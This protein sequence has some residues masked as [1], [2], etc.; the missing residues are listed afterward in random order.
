MR[1]KPVAAVLLLVL[2]AGGG[3]WLFHGHAPQNQYRLAAVEKGPLV[4]TVSASGTVQPV[5]V[6]NV[7]ASTAGILTGLL[8]DFNSEVKAGQPVARLDPASAEAQLAVSRANLEVARSAIDINRAQ[9]EHAKDDALNAQAQLDEA[10]TEVE[11]STVAVAQSGRDF[12]RMRSLSATGDV[13]RSESERARTTYES[14]DSDVK[15]AK[16]K[17]V[18]AGAALAGAQAAAQVADAQLNNAVAAVAAQEAAVRLAEQEVDR[19]LIRAPIDGVVLQRNA[20]LGQPVAPSG[21]PLFVIAQD[22]SNVQVHASV[23]EADIGRVTIGQGATL[24]FD[25]Y[26]DDSF[27]GKVIGIRKT[28]Q[29]SQTVVTYDVVVSVDNS[30]LKLLPG[31]TADT[32]IIVSRSDDAVKVPNAAL[33]VSAAALHLDAAAAGGASA[34]EQGSATQQIWQLDAKGQPRA[35]MVHTGLTDGTYTEVVDGGLAPGQQVIVGMVPAESAA[36]VGPLKF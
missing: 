4:S 16:A 29:I 21:V 12:Q 36:R 34:S 8:V 22:L 19:T 10:H 26:P 3:Y 31:M 33:R 23:D 2:A 6:V 5:L 18:A 17:E 35:H 27:D 24:S 30:A 28:P 9:V 25:A 1:W 7:T 20:V 13:P 15:S 32:R 11:H 14:A